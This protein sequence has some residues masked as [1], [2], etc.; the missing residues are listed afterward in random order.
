MRGTEDVGRVRCLVRMPDVA[1]VEITYLVG[2]RSASARRQLVVEE[3]GKMSFV[4]EIRRLTEAS[5]PS[6]SLEARVAALRELRV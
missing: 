4:L 5:H 2:S 1:G 3:V 6:Q